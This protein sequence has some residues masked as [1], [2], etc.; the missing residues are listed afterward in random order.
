MIYN[1]LGTTGIKVPPIIFGTSC[2]GNLYQA[3]PAQT[4][5]NIVKEMFGHVDSPVAMD[6][7]GKYGAG[8]ALEEIGRCLTE[9]G[10]RTEDVVISN[11]LGWRRV[12]LQT[13]EPTFETGVWA[14]LEFDAEQDISY[15]GIL[16]CW[17]Q[18][19][20]LLGDTYIPQL[21]SVHDPDEYLAQAVSESDRQKYFDDIIGAYQALTE[22]REQGQAKAVG[23]GS[24]DWQVIRELSQTVKLDWVMFANSMTIFSHPPELL[25][26]ID[27][28]QQQDVAVINSAV[29]NAGFLTGGE[30]FDYRKPDPN[31]P[32]DKAI[33]EWR[34]KFFAACQ[35]FD[36][37]PANACVQFGMSPPGVV[38]IALNT[39][40]PERVQQNVASVTADIPAEFWTTL[41]A[42]DLIAQEYPYLG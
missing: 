25:V 40:K 6:S 8:L 36:V 14:D 5:L 29:F 26:F 17:E 20:E 39:S 1:E 42:K 12:P 30:Y 16:R 10:T 15:D 27:Q 13:P 21:I 11:K 24:K 38:S 33:F 23:V 31:D 19:C 22:L 4:K 35:Y 34:E 9:L 32:D 18:G 3:L 7:A 28:L 41:K 2:L 37:L